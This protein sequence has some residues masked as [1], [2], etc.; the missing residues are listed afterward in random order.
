MAHQN[1]VPAQVTRMAVIL[2]Y[3]VLVMWLERPKAA[4]YE[5]LLPSTSS[6]FLN[7]ASRGV[8][9]YRCLS[10]M[11]LPQPSVYQKHRSRYGSKTDVQSGRKSVKGRW[12][13]R[14][15]IM[16]F[17]T[18]PFPVSTQ[19]VIIYFT[20]C[21]VFQCCIDLRPNAFSMSTLRMHDL[22]NLISSR[23]C[24]KSSHICSMS[25]ICL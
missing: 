10:A 6:E 19:L 23:I 9:T 14:N 17:L 12:M 21:I 3:R 25:G 7:R 1:H 18:D 8:T 2:R 13:M 5:Q 15:S 24:Y 11:P 4:G 22:T 16:N 20:L